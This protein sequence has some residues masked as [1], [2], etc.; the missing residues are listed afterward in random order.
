MT[1]HGK[2]VLIGAAIVVTALAAAIV[3]YGPALAFLMDIAGYHGSIRAL[4][5]A[6]SATFTTSD[7]TVPTRWGAIAARVYTPAGRA[8]RTAVVFPGV[9]GGG[10]DE[11]RLAL[12]C[13]RLA[14]TGLTVVCTPLPELREFRITSRSTDAIEDVTDWAIAQPALAPRQ[15]VALVGVSF[16]GGLALVAAGRDSLRNHLDVVLSVGGYGDLPRALRYLCTGQLPDG[17]T[18][19]PHD[20]GLAVIALAA[21]PRLVPADQ[22]AVLEGGI[23]TFLEASLDDS[24][25]GERARPLIAAARAAAGGM[26]EPARGILTDILDRNVARVG[27][28]LLP[29]LEELGQDPALSPDRSPITSAPVFI[30]HGRDDNVIPSTETP[31]VAADLTRRGNPRVRWLLTPLLSHAELAG[32]AAIGDAWRLLS[33]WHQVLGVLDARGPADQ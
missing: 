18:R 11:P 25:A 30:I 14:S 7:V 28:L 3:T 15:R 16:S 22:V 9:H 23:L 17:S 26:P 6:R 24:P 21:A 8:T 12:F 31:L 20:Y 32:G 5:P 19:P 2:R 27:A 29:L 1:V 10:V 4:L 13:G 33:F